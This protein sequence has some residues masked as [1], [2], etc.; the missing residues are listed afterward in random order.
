MDF[1]SILDE[2]ERRKSGRGSSARRLEEL[3]D[4][5]APTA[6]DLSPE[7][8]AE[9]SASEDESM[10]SARRLPIESELDLHGFTVAE[11]ERALDR[12]LR[13]SFTRGLT[14][15]LI[16]HG[17]GNHSMDGGKLKH[18]VLRS[19]ERHPLAGA[20]GVPDRTLGGS[21][22]VWVRVRQRSR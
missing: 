4:Q 6:E 9:G 12:F 13:E 20:R 21:G 3:I 18:A 11:A 1:G 19:L 7:D 14:K 2:W 16:I 10:L 15:V 5:Y 8:E 22:A 17:K